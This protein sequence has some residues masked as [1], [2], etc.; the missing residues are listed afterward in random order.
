MSTLPP[1]IPGI[2]THNTSKLVPPPVNG[3]GIPGPTVYHADDYVDAS[4]LPVY[5]AIAATI[6][7]LILAKRFHNYSTWISLIGYFLTPFLV[8]I[9]TGIDSVQQR[10]KAATDEYFV[11][12]NSYSKILRALSA[13]SILISIPHITGIAV[14][15]AAW[16]AT[17]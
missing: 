1:P 17:L 9:C 3:V 16:V 10:R 8:I 14:T 11:E 7:S 2:P 4:K 6:I 13:L 15:V 12:K 5:I